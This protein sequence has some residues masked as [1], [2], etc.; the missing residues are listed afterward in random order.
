MTIPSSQTLMEISN[1]NEQL[2]KYSWAG[3]PV[4][5]KSHDSQV[6]GAIELL[7]QTIVQ[8]WTFERE[9]STNVHYV[10]MKLSVENQLKVNNKT[11]LFIIANVLSHYIQMKM[12]HSCWL[13][14]SLMAIHRSHDSYFRAFHTQRMSHISLCINEMTWNEKMRML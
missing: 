13:I 3:A 12:S 14:S 5:H 10:I 11:T 8:T 9:Y 4:N 7:K 1:A 6:G 2:I